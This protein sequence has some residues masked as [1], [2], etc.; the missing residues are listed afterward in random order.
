MR[1][2]CVDDEA[3][4]LKV[5]ENAVSQSP[6]I[7]D[8]KA[9][10]SGKAAIEYA[11][12]NPIDIAFL[13]IEIRQMTG[14]ELAQILRETYPK[15]IVVFCTGYNQY[16]LDAFKIHA[17]GYL[18][19]PITPT[20]VQE[21]IDTIK[22]LLG[23]SDEKK[24]EVKCFGNFEVFYDG[25]PI[26][27]K[28]SRTKELFAYLVDRNGAECKAAEIISVLFEDVYNM[29][30]Y[31]KLRKDLIKTFESIGFDNCINVT[32]GGLSVNRDVLDCDYFDFKDGKITE[33]PTEYMTQYSFAEYTF[34]SLGV[35]E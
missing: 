29:E 30:Y 33:M 24:I 32:Y 22:S 6:D 16:A 1:A 26:K 23:V 8:V 17:N 4:L 18:T 19:K 2:I 31:S 5:L 25:K 12:E 15:L 11:K 35:E 3:I 13:D 9:F 7:S 14:I 20:A 27:F 34:S 10:S 21:Q 28:L